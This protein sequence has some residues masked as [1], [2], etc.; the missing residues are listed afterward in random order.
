MIVESGVQALYG[1]PL[2]VWSK[3]G[4][5]HGH[6]Y[7]LVSHELLDFQERSSLLQETVKRAQ[8]QVGGQS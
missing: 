2:S 7:V 6:F 1:K 4:V 8:L 3:M 5:A